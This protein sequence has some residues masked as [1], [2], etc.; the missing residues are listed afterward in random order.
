MKNRICN[1]IIALGLLFFAG[2]YSSHIGCHC[3]ENEVG[4]STMN[5]TFGCGASTKTISA[6][7]NW[8]IIRANTQDKNSSYGDF[9]IICL[10]GCEEETESVPV[11]QSDGHLCKI[12]G[13]WFEIVEITKNELSIS[14]TKNETNVE[15]DLYVRIFNGPCVDILTVTQK[16]E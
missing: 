5:L 11:C 8:W 6:S 1:I 14:V 13:D 3:D 10:R 2:C 12:T 9:D 15:R 7:S 16:A 4:L